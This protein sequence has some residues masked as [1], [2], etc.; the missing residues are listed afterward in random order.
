MNAIWSGAVLLVLGLLGPASAQQTVSARP[1]IDWKAV[2]G[3]VEPRVSLAARARIGGTLVE[4][5][6][7]EGD[8]VE[9][10]Q[11]IA[12]VVDEKIGIQLA[13][14]ESQRA[15]LESQLANARVEQERNAALVERGVAT[16][17]QRDA[18]ATQVKVL[19]DQVAAQEA[20]IR[21]IEEQSA[22]GA[23]LSPTAGTVTAVPQAVGA[24]LM[25]GEAVAT[26]GGGGF[27]LRLAIPERHAAALEPGASIRLE[28]PEGE[29]EG[30]LAKVYPQ[31]ENGRVIADVEVPDLDARFVNARMLVRV[32][33]GERQAITVPA[34]AVTNV[35]GL[36]MVAVATDHGP[37]R[38]LVVTGEGG[39][40][41][42]GPEVEII[43][44]L[45]EGDQVYPD[46][47]AAP[48]P[49]PVASAAADHE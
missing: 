16:R 14:A 43:S 44:G 31:I 2:Y 22:E 13:A 38:R 5:T 17:Q 18:L 3:R 40:G 34:A 4:L 19:E 32:P 1:V 23:V 41:P 7:A 6:V 10:G 36:D 33:V 27:F 39:P 20:Q 26:I 28:T 47:A 37:V 11:E 21:L 35:S 29:A 46:A 15:A 45:A 30:R 25:P 8:R 9:A 42:D 48:A 49:E 24:V 12:R